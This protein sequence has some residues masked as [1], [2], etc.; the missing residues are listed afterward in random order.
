M[1]PGFDEPALL[2]DVNL[3]GEHRRGEAV[4][5]QD[6][7]PPLRQTAKPPEPIRLRPGVHR[8]CRLIEHDDRRLPKER[9]RQGHPLPF[10]DAQL[11]ALLKP[12]SEQVFVSVRQAF[13]ESPGAG[14]DG[15]G[16]HGFIGRDACQ[17]AKS[18]IV[19]DGRVV[20]H[21]LLEQHRNPAAQFLDR[22]TA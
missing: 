17:I 12:M 19:T 6:R 8:A 18:N 10:A 4:R 3:V 20:A 11:G 15:G 7:G 14:V 21:R 1:R 9:P 16:A 22:K 5:D 13:N 2:H